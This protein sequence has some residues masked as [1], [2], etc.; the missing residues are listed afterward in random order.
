MNTEHQLKSK[1][2]W[3]ACPKSIKLKQKC[4]GSNDY[5]YKCFYWVITWKLLFSGGEDWLLVGKNGEGGDF[6]RVYEQTFG[7][8]GGPLPHPTPVQ[9]TLHSLHHP[10]C[11]RGGGLS[12]WSNFQKGE[13][14]LTRS[15][16]LQGVALPK[17]TTG[18]QSLTI[19][20]AFVTPWK[21][22]QMVIMTTH[23]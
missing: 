6:S 11:W 15:Q 19:A 17:R 20:T 9:K 13:R 3:P 5:S 12:L 4:S 21:F 14:G 23:T 10:F 18:Q 1:L 22:H 8:W 16:F 2:T 7:W